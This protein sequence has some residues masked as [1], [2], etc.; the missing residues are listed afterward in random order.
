[1]A[2]V[3]RHSS[4]SSVELNLKFDQ[5]NVTMIIHDNGRGFDLHAPHGGLGLSSMRERCEGLGGSFT[6]E[7]T[8][9]QGTRIVASLPTAK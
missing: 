5:I 7:S 4:A 9:G 1:M 8:P 3:A 2:N 6:I